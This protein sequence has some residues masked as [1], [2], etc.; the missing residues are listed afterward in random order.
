MHVHESKCCLNTTWKGC[1]S[2][3]FQRWQ[4]NVKLKLKDPETNCGGWLFFSIIADWLR[5]RLLLRSFTNNNLQVCTFIL[6][7]ISLSVFKTKKY[8]IQ[9]FWTFLDRNIWQPPGINLKTA[10]DWKIY[11]VLASNPVTFYLVRARS[12]EYP[13]KPPIGVMTH[14]GL[15]VYL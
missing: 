8:I 1:I 9:C 7:C 3:Y 15:T 6:Y 13:F 2:F 12:L 11:V 10:S 4:N 14:S 5:G